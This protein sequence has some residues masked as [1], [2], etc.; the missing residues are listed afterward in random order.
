MTTT[1]TTT[2]IPEM[3]IVEPRSVDWREMGRGLNGMLAL[4]STH[5]TQYCSSDTHRPFRFT[6][7]LE[8]TKDRVHIASNWEWYL[9]DLREAL[10][11]RN[12]TI[13]RHLFIEPEGVGALSWGKGKVKVL[14]DELV[15]LARQ[16]SRASHVSLAASPQDE[17]ARLAQ[18]WKIAYCDASFP[19]DPAEGDWAS[20]TFET[21]SATEGVVPPPSW[22]DIQYAYRR[23]QGDIPEYIL[24][25][26]GALL[27]TGKPLPM[28]TRASCG[29]LSI[30]LCE[31]SWHTVVADEFVP[32]PKDETL[33]I[34]LLFFVKCLAK[35]AGGYRVLHEMPETDCAPGEVFELLLGLPFSVTS[36]D[37]NFEMLEGLLK[38]GYCAVVTTRGGGCFPLLKC[39]EYLDTRI[40][41]IARKACEHTLK[42]EKPW[43]KMSSFRTPDGYEWIEG[44]QV[45]SVTV[46]HTPQHC[47]VQRLGVKV[48]QF[49]P[50]AILEGRIV[51][52][53]EDSRYPD[54]HVYRE[55]RA[56]EVVVSAVQ[57]DFPV[58]LTL[59]RESTAGKDDWLIEANS[60]ERFAP[61]S[62]TQRV[63]VLIP[64][65]SRFIVVVR[66]L[67]DDV[68]TVNLSVMSSRELTLA[69]YNP[70]PQG[71]LIPLGFEAGR[72]PKCGKR[73]SGIPPDALDVSYCPTVHVPITTETVDG[74]G[75]SRV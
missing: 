48:A 19:H 63:H 22:Q 2:P 66:P 13:P 11:V 21:L 29:A 58:C 67:T 60:V 65:G 14:T 37:R 8:A 7:T 16:A 59:V 17:V 12:K 45:Q 26:L 25:V 41:L 42:A 43:E 57:P 33:H 68:H 35:L 1:T 71:V 4:A 70:S 51:E 75:G 30:N 15:V 20:S 18:R 24:A 47:R 62:A 38:K 50:Q 74:Y 9:G 44:T 6:D 39:D 49:V 55:G 23:Q 64:L 52:V 40:L 3:K 54:D 36:D 27:H 56:A 32:V 46:S 5:Y 10:G 69:T 34:W 31:G 72:L 28:I 73:Y 61:C 53:P